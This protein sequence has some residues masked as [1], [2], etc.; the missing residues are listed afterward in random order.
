MGG[1]LVSKFLSPLFPAWLKVCFRPINGVCHINAWCLHEKWWEVT[2]IVR[3]NLQRTTWTEPA[4]L[5]RGFIG[6]HSSLY[7]SFYISYVRLSFCALLNALLRVSGCRWLIL[8]IFALE[9]RVLLGHERPHRRYHRQEDLRDMRVPSDKIQT[10]RTAIKVC[11]CPV[12]ISSLYLSLCL[13]CRPYR[14]TISNLA[15]VP[16]P[17]WTFPHTHL[18]Q[19]N[20]VILLALSTL[21]I[22]FAPS[23]FTC[24]PLRDSY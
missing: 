19:P 14:F 15:L 18:R 9:R 11:S 6:G 4:F 24:P 21:D 13:L 1:H 17:S 5:F 7:D 2:S 23:F 10:L 22:A 16:K 8:S 3:N 12:L 20:I